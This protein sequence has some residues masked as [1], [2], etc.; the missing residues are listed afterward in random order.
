MLEGESW[1]DCCALL[2]MSDNHSSA[3]EKLCRGFHNYVKMNKE[4]LTEV[5]IDHFIDVTERR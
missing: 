3:T 1:W 4:F 5:Q 2:W